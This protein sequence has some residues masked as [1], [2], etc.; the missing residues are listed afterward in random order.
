MVVTVDVKHVYKY[1]FELVAQTHF[2][3]VGKMARRQIHLA[4]ASVVIYL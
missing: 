4:A 2:N 1:P 3:K